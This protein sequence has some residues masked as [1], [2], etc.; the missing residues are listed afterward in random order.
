MKRV[1][2]KVSKGGRQQVRIMKKGLAGGVILI[3]QKEEP[4][5]LACYQI[6]LRSLQVS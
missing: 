2:E 1:R 5:F 3:P 4:R 6:S